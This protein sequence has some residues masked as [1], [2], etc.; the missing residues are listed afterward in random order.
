MQLTQSPHQTDPDDYKLDKSTT[1]AAALGNPCLAR[2]LQPRYRRAAQ[3]PQQVSLSTAAGP[4][5]APDTHGCTLGGLRRYPKHQAVFRGASAT[6]E[7]C[8]SFPDRAFRAHA[9]QFE[10][11]NRHISPGKGDDISPASPGKGQR[12]LCASAPT[13]SEVTKAKDDRS[14]VF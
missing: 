8:C 1:K 3:T 6:R 13:A 4:A 9:P 14:N 2:A 10:Q 7:L 11:V 5:S 12:I